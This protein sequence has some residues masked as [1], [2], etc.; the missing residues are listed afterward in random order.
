MILNLFSV[1]A[2]SVMASLFKS[3]KKLVLASGS[4]RRKNYFRQLGLDFAVSTADIDES[5]RPDELP[6]HYVIR[7][8][9]GKAQIIMSRFPA[10]W[11][12]AADTIVSLGNEIFGKPN[13]AR[14][15]HK[16]LKTL[17]SRTHVVQTAVCC[18]CNLENK[19]EILSVKTEVTFTRLSDDMIASYVATGE[20]FD[21]A[22]GYGIQGLG[23]F[24]ITD[25]SGSYS[26]VVGMPLTQTLS[27]LM[28]ND[29]IA[30]V[31][32]GQILRED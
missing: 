29:V 18:G 2:H 15:A 23:A 5:A 22:G 11:V 8:A 30:P 6:S 26:N 20:P 16:M 13:G 14:E 24:L 3:K 4:P 21:K 1:V 28:K 31:S 9:R 10:H 17:S 12:V 7:M 19:Q 27:M 32:D 25:V